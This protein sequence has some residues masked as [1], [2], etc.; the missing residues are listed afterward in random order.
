MEIEEGVIS[1]FKLLFRL[2]L[3]LETSEISAFF[4]FTTKTTQP[5]ALVFSVKGALTC[6]EAALLTPLVD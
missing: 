6:K 2:V 4:V 5:R 1:C 3:T